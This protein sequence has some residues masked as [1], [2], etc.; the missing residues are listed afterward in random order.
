M[1][2]GVE[3]KRTTAGDW[4]FEPRMTTG[5]LPAAGP[6]T[7]FIPVACGGGVGK[8]AENS[9]V[10]FEGSVAVAVIQGPSAGPGI[11]TSNEALPPASVIAS[12]APRGFCAGPLP[13]ASQTRLAKSSMRNVSA[14]R[15]LSVPA[16]PV[17]LGERTTEETIGK[18]CSRFGPGSG[19]PGSFGVTPA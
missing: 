11:A 16:I 3:P 10:S 6:D 1:D 15:L 9:E 7:G 14:A 13:D 8:H 17:E 5:V 12:A 18:F 4:K 19:S 2:A